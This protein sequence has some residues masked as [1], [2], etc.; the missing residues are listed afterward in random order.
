[1]SGAQVEVP[2]VI[3]ASVGAGKGYGGQHC[4][5]LESLFTHIPGLVRRL[6]GHRGRRQGPAQVGDPDEQPGPVRREPGPL[7]D[8]GRRARGRAPRARSAWRDV[9][10]EGT[11]VTLV[12]WGPAVLDCLA[13]AETLA[14]EHGVECRGHRPAQPRAARHGDRA[15]VGP[16]DRPLRGGR[17]AVLVGSFVNEIVARDPGARPSTT[18]TRRW[19]GSAPRTASRR[20]RRASS[21]RSCPTRATSS[22]AVLAIGCTDAEDRRHGRTRSCMPKPGQMT[23][24]C[25]VLAWHKTRGRPRSRKG[26]VL[27]EIETDKSAMEVEAF[28]EGV[29]LRIVV[30]EGDDRPVNTICAWVGE[31][32]RGDP[33]DAG[34]AGGRRRPPAAASRPPAPAAAPLPGRRSPER[35]RP[36]RPRA[37]PV[38]LP[39]A[40]ACAISPRASRLAA[41]RGHRPAHD[42]R[43]RPE[44]RIVERDVRAAIAARAARRPAAAPGRPRRAAGARRAGAARRSRSRSTARRSRGR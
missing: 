35:R 33:R 19:R 4:Q 6:P 36:P 42:H 31:A 25:T 30:A 11:D 8:E 18:S 15:R 29:L 20:R 7:R 40:P 24:E 26:D 14:A 1:M 5:S 2:L 37:A 22:A 44:G 23:E 32:G 10:R 39:R 16:Q 41:E 3:R 21:R 38:P 12:A 43:H 28:D 34:R 27:F 17:Q 13:A 9:A